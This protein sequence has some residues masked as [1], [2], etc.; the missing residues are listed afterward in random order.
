MFAKG[1]WTESAATG[2]LFPDDDIDAMLLEFRRAHLRFNEIPG[3]HKLSYFAVRQLAALCDKYDLVKMV[4]P[5]LDSNDWALQYRPDG[6]GSGPVHA[7]WLSISWTFGYNESFE[8]LAEHL[9]RTIS[10]TSTTGPSTEDGLK[11]KTISF[12]PD[13]LGKS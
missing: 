7:S 1:R 6:T 4:Q 8:W 13:I 2:I 5:F 11:T 3:K 12:P 9:A 10:A